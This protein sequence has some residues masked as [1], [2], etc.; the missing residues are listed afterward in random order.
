MGRFEVNIIT[1]RLTPTGEWDGGD[2]SYELVGRFDDEDA[3]R[4]EA[5]RAAARTKRAAAPGLERFV[6]LSDRVDRVYDEDFA[7]AD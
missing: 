2:L 6:R 1:Q 7:C 4:A 3:A 5:Q